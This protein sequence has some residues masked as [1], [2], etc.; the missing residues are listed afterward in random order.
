MSKNNG[1]KGIIVLLVAIIV[2]LGVLCA[3]FATDTISLNNK[4]PENNAVSTDLTDKSNSIKNIYD[5]NGLNVKPS[6]DYPNF[7]DISDKANIVESVTVGN[8]Y[9][10]DLDLSG[11]VTVKSIGND[12]SATGTLNVI[13]V[14]DIIK[15]DVPADASQQLLYLLTDDGEVYSYK[16]GDIDNNSFNATKVDIVSNVKKIFISSYTGNNAGG[17][18]ALFA[19]TD[20]NDCIMLNCTSV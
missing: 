10:A 13:N 9:S 6:A 18:W 19:I 3:L 20:N 16:F 8:D 4:T 5:V 7:S 15:F 12:K 14:I 11:K 2:C 1:N 17:S